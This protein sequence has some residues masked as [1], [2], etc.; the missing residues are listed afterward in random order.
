MMPLVRMLE[1]A[2][3]AVFF[4]TPLCVANMRN[5]SA[6]E[7]I[8][9][10]QNIRGLLIFLKFQQVR[11]RSPLARSAH[12]RHVV[13]ALLVDPTLI[14]E[15]QQI[16]VRVGDEQMFDEVA[17]LALSPFD[18]AATAGLSAIRVAGQSLDVAIVRDGDDD[19]FLRDEAFEVVGADVAGD[20][21]AAVVAVFLHHLGSCLRE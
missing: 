18:A 12:F 5:A 11:D 17:F 8:L 1:Y 4:T 21:R 16:I 7:K 19:V 13:H 3:S 14:G 10:R 9:N 15:K 6:F 2:L 20:L